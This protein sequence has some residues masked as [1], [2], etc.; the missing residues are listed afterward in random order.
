M[1]T[2]VNI[3]SLAPR[4]RGVVLVM[5]MVFLLIL[6]LIGVTTMSTTVLQEKMA[7]NMQDKNA[8]FQAA[9]SALTSGETGC[10]RWPRCPYSTHRLPMMAYTGSPPPLPPCGI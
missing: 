4:E 3:I 8:A 5:A 1:Y 10:N 7:G 2:S 9:E 6:T